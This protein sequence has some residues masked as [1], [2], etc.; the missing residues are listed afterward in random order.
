MQQQFDPTA[1]LDMP[2]DVPLERRPPLPAVDYVGTIT[3]V[4]AT[5]WTSK[6]KTDEMGRPKSGIRFDLAIRIDIPLNV[7]ESLGLKTDDMSLKD[8]IMIDMNAQG[9]ISTEPGANSRLRAYREALG[10]NKPGEVFRPRD[11]EGRRLTVKVKH[12]EYNGN[13]QERVG[14]IAAFA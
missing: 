14:A 2:I 9:G 6:D 3:A 5:Q 1:Y 10:M 7:K 11:M 4:T 8:S 12:E 13:I